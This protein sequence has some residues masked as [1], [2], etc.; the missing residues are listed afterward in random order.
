MTIALLLLINKMVATNSEGRRRAVREASG[1]NFKLL[2]MKLVN[3]SEEEIYFWEANIFSLSQEITLILWNP[4]IR[5]CIQNCR[6][7]SLS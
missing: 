5:Y 2:N 7:L 3:D 1:L 4:N 6:H